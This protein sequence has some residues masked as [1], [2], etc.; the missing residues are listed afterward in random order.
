MCKQKRS[1]SWDEDDNHVLKPYL[2]TTTNNQR[3]LKRK[4]QLGIESSVCLAADTRR[5]HSAAES[6]FIRSP[7]EAY[8]SDRLLDCWTSTHW[9][10]TNI[11]SK[12]YAI[13]NEF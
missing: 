2:R 9:R 6:T 12:L 1:A 3:W 5:S 10:M 7:Q 8:M 4:S 13:S 11:P